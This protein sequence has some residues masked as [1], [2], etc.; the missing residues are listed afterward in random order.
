MAMPIQKHP[1]KLTSIIP[2]GII[3]KYECFIKSFMRYLSGAPMAPPRAKR[4]NLVIME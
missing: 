4:I 2:L 1:R 3:K